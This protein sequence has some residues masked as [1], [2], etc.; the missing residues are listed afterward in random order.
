M[1]LVKVENS[2]KE[3]LTKLMEE[4]GQITTNNI[5]EFKSGR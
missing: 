3:V 2:I 1:R 5:V 4:E